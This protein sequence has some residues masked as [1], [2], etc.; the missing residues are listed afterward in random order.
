M[1]EVS[2]S[3]EGW[4]SQLAEA[5]KLGKDMNL[6]T[7]QMAER[8]EQV[9]DFLANKIDPKNSE[10]K[11]LQELWGAADEQEQKTI[12]GVLIKLVSGARVH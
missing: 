8:A 9:G 4:K 11:V 2:G 6:S 5:V 12:A 3:W 1:P 7:E 10:Q